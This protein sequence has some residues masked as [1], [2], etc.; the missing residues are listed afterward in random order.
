MYPTSF[1]YLETYAKH[2]NPDEIREIAQ[3]DQ[4]QLVRAYHYG[5]PVNTKVQVK[6]EQANQRRETKLNRKPNHVY[7]FLRSLLFILQRF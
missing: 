6:G 1:S 5:D 3:R 7:A 2:R 4:V